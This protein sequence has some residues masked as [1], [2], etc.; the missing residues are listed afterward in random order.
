MALGKATQL[1][2]AKQKR[3]GDFSFIR[4]GIQ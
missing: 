1:G 3:V 2:G 4:L